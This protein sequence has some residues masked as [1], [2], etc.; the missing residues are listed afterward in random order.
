MR[1]IYAEATLEVRP[2]AKASIAVRNIENAFSFGRAKAGAYGPLT[3]SL[4]REDR[5][6]RLACHRLHQRSRRCFAPP[7]HGHPNFFGPGRY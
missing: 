6:F 1:E 5:D 3:V 2:I 7:P 4:A